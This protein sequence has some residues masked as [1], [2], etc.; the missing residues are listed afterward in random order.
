[1]SSELL[2]L[3]QRILKQF[4]FIEITA[5]ILVFIRELLGGRD[6]GDFIHLGISGLVIWGL[7]LLKKKNHA[8][9]LGFLRVGV[10]ISVVVFSLWLG[11]L[12]Y[13]TLILNN[14]YSFTLFSMTKSM[15]FVQKLREWVTVL[16]YCFYPT[17]LTWILLYNADK[18]LTY[19]KKSQT[20]A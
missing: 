9:I 20:Q 14:E 11:Y 6:S 3:N 4:F 16:E 10:A 19:V 13:D 15:T 18:A 8:R 2:K 5:A 1:M 7:M 17:A 12:A